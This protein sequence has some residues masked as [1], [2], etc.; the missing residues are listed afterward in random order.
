MLKQHSLTFYLTILT[1]FLVPL[2]PFRV[3]IGPIPLSTEVVLIPLL[4][5]SFVYDYWKKNIRLNAFPIKIFL[6]LL[7]A[8]A[9]ISVVSLTQAQAP[10]PGILEIVRFVSYIFLF[11][12]VTKT[13]FTYREYVTIAT[14]FLMSV[15]LV[16]TYGI[17]SFVVDFNLNKAGLYALTEAWGRVGSTFTNPN[18]FAGLINFILPAFLFLSILYFTRTRTKLLFFGFFA[19]LVISQIFTYT[20]SA[21]F[22]MALAIIMVLMTMPKRFWNGF[23][24]IPMVIAALLLAISVVNLPDVQERTTS[25]FFVIESLIPTGMLQFNSEES[26]DQEQSDAAA[27]NKE[28]TERAVVS[29]TTLW[30]TGWV[31]FKDNPVLGV[32]AGNYLV[33]YSDYTEKYPELYVGHDAY[34]VHNSF[35]KVASETGIFGLLSFLSIYLYLLYFI[36]KEFLK[37]RNKNLLNQLLLAGLF[38]G[39]GTFLGQNLANNLIFIPQ[40]NVIFWLVTGLTLSYVYTTYAHKEKIIS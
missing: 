20:R 2:I 25:A 15:L 36:G 32:G 7:G 30:K 35:L 26:P 29:R 23:K 12:I 18:Y 5:L 28:S 22:I 13:T 39:T 21:W 10:L 11:I 3:E 16:V 38:I 33:R 8:F 34:S 4:T 24:S 31:M 37:N 17:F 1:I 40:L 19:L 9:F 27:A 6:I 14:T